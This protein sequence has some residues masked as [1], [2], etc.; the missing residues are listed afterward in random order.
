METSSNSKTL[1]LTGLVSAAALLIAVAENINAGQENC[2]N[3][4]YQGCDTGY[5]RPNSTGHQYTLHWEYR[6][7]H[8][9]KA[10]AYAL[11]LQL[12]L[13]QKTPSQCLQLK[14]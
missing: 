9:A 10:T 7:G 12:K 13:T 4:R 8:K 11:I 2:G 3:Y 14:M 6:R 5:Q 1:T